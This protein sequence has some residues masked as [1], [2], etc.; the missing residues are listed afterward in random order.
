MLIYLDIKIP[1]LQIAHQGGNLEVG[2]I[3]IHQMLTST[4]VAKLNIERYNFYGWNVVKEAMSEYW[5]RKISLFWEGSIFV[6]LD[7]FNLYFSVYISPISVLC[8]LCL[9]SAEE[10][11][12]AEWRLMG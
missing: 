4:M 3:K 10:I 9:S 6:F 5:T 12:C 8:F 2:N 1:H 7:K 11:V